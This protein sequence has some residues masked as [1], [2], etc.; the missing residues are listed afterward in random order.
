MTKVK[1]DGIT[2]LEDA[3]YCAAQGAA[4]LG[5]IFAPSPRR[6]E[7][8][9]VQAISAA[10]PPFVLKVGVFVN[11]DPLHI[12]ELMRECG[13]DIAQLHGEEGPEE[14]EVLEGRVIKT[15]RAGRDEPDLKWR[16]VPLRGILIDTFN[17]DQAGGTGQT[18][19][20]EVFAA[21]RSLGSPLIL[22]GGLNPKNIQEALRATRPDGVDVSSGVEAAPGKKDPAKVAAFMAA[23]RG[24]QSE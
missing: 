18:F 13:L 24:F 1:I 8:A 14:A 23:V 3:E 11:E 17:P 6:V 16:G 9:T 5:F 19:D 2:N 22:A 7:A 21:Y 12:K 15:F 20:W 4:A 10:L